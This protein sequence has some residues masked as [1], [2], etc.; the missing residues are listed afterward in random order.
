MPC[1]PPLRACLPRDRPEVQGGSFPCPFPGG[2]GPLPWGKHLGCEG[3][4]PQVSGRAVQSPSTG[5]AKLG[6]A[7]RPGEPAPR[8]DAAGASWRHSSRGL[9]PCQAPLR[10][11]G[12]QPPRPARWVMGGSRCIPLALRAP[13]G[14]QADRL[15]SQQGRGA[16]GFALALLEAGL[17]SPSRFYPAI[18][19][20]P[21]HVR[22]WREQGG[23]AGPDQRSPRAGPNPQPWRRGR[24]PIT[25]PVRTGR[26]SLGL[27][28]AP[29]GLPPSPP[30]PPCSPRGLGSAVQPP[31]LP[32]D[33]PPLHPRPARWTGS[34]PRAWRGAG[35]R[36]SLCTQ[37]SG[38]RR[39]CPCTA[40]P[41]ASW[42]V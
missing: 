34:L 8:W 9:S 11:C 38:A 20:S 39:S 3:R 37:H 21:R 1:C 4:V 30:C 19:C 18:S 2:P 36:T 27:W 41:G 12:C 29:P 42:H 26:N 32:G 14:K 6:V 13:Q 16:P 5:Q 15:G 33:A 28:T 10:P 35:G 25:S 17:C 24:P 23:S 31:S 22:Q 7:G 40:W